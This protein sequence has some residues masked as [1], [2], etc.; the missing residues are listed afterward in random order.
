MITDE[1]WNPQSRQ[2]PGGTLRWP[3]A[4][5]PDLLRFS[6]MA[7]AMWLASLVDAALSRDWV[8]DVGGRSAE[9]APAH[10]LCEIYF[11]FEVVGR[12]ATTDGAGARQV[13]EVHRAR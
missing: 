9:C 4:Q 7:R 6:G 5:M 1:R 8:A 10:L 2:S 11:R 12:T 13:Y 3:R